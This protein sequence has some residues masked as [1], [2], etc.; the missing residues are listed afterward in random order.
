MDDFSE[1]QQQ[2]ADID[3]M[4]CKRHEPRRKATMKSYCRGF[5]TCAHQ[6][7]LYSVDYSSLC[8]V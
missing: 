7:Q 5:F 2:Y 3:R 4:L 8:E 1:K 6:S